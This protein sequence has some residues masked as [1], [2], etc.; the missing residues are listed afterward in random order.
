MGGCDLDTPHE[1]A[2]LLL[3][4]TN[5]SASP[6]GGGVRGVAAHSPQ[7]DTASVASRP[8]TM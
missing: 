1:V 3:R 5:V 6:K 2:P 4:F 8:Q 7:H